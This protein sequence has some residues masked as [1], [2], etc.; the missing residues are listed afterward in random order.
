[1]IKSSSTR[2]KSRRMCPLN[3]ES[4]GHAAWLRETSG[5]PNMIFSL[6]HSLFHSLFLSPSQS[7]SLALSLSHSLYLSFSLILPLYHSLPPCTLIS[8]CSPCSHSLLYFRDNMTSSS[9]TLS[10]PTNC[11]LGPGSTGH[12]K[13]WTSGAAS[14]FEVSGS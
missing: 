2:W 7:L 14:R 10:P 3:E 13:L 12:D 4:L 11:I 9:L 6:F 1:M 5:G 8:P